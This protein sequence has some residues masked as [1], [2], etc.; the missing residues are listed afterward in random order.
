ML[1]GAAFTVVGVLPRGHRLGLGLFVPELYVPISALVAPS[2]DDRRRAAF[3]L[4]ARLAPGTTRLQ[5]A[6]GGMLASVVMVLLA[7]IRFSITLTL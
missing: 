2:L 6:G 5:G 1:N 3:D 7:R 4:R